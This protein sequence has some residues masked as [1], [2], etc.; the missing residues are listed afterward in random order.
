MSPMS[1]TAAGASS[2]NS[3]RRARD[4]SGSPAAL[5]TARIRAEAHG[6]SR[7]EREGDRF[8]D[9]EVGE[10]P[11]LRQ[12][13]PYLGAGARLVKK[14]GGVRAVEEQ[15]R[16]APRKSLR[17]GRKLGIVAGEIDHLRADECLNRIAGGDRSAC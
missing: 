17:A 13:D 12:R 15:A 2:S 10:A 7:V 4:A 14:H 16:H 6:A 9:S 1:Q 5:T 11:R 8:T 3:V